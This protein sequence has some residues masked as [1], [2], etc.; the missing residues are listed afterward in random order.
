MLGKSLSF[1]VVMCINLNTVIFASLF[2]TS[3]CHL[4]LII[5]R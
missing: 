5:L 3:G 4:S 2:E 1:V